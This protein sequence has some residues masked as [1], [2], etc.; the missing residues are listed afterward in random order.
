VEGRVYRSQKA[1]YL[2]RMSNVASTRGPRLQV[3]YLLE[4]G[5][6]P[7]VYA[8]TEK[9]Q[10]QHLCRARQE[11]VRQVCGE[12]GLPEPRVVTV[13]Q[14]RKKARQ[15]LSDLLAVQAPPFA[16]CADNDD[17]AFAALAALSDLNLAVPEAISV[18]GHDN[19]MIAELSN[20][21]LTTIGLDNP[22]LAERLIAS[23]LSV[24]QGGLCWTSAPCGQ[25]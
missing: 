18:I 7:M 16:L 8:A 20:P 11:I 10:L 6:R 12:H 15:Q 2:E 5:S 13:S 19:T 23:V 22:D 9:P 17:V 21:P 24:C 25:R 1:C 4:Q 14:S 3:E